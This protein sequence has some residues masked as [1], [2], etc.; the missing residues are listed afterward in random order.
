MRQQRQWLILIELITLSVSA[1]LLSI[2][3]LQDAVCNLAL[4]HEVKSQN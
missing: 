3:A 2:V 4:L 1:A